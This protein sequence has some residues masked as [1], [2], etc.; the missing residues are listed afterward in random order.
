MFA[1]LHVYQVEPAREPTIHEV[2]AD[3]LGDLFVW[4]HLQLFQNKA[5]T[6][7][8]ILEEW[9]RLL[10]TR[11]KDRFPLG[12]LTHFN[13]RGARHLRE[14]YESLP[15][16]MEVLGV[17]YPCH[18]DVDDFRIVGQ[19]PVMRILESPGKGR[20]G[21]EVQIISLDTR[22]SRAP[23][24]FEARRRISYLLSKYGIELDL[25]NHMRKVA[26]QTTSAV[27]LPH[28]PKL[29]PVQLDGRS[30]RQA[31]VWVKWVFQC[32]RQGFFF[33]RAGIACKRCEFDKV[34]D[35]RYVTDRA[36]ENV[37]QTRDEIRRNL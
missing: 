27:Y 1:F 21:R 26:T 11:C 20:S 7:G 2:W 13:N 9:E 4:I 17:L 30:A 8:G 12:D 22:T 3:T 29:V 24:T 18:R 35:V 23:T 14:L 10:T 5:V 28:F 25:R 32:I 15:E 34:C 37:N 19:V 31:L 36:L 16:T 33:P 6:W